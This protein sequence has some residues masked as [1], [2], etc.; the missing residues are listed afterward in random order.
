MLPSPDPR[1]GTAD[2]AGGAGRVTI[3]GP[4]T[5]AGHELPRTRE[6]VA[7]APA[8]A[9]AVGCIRDWT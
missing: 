3:A 5:V 2:G 7:A 8:A 1:P 4:G 6:S 9:V